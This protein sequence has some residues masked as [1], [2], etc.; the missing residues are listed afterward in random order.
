MPHDAREGEQ[1]PYLDEACNL[2]TLGCDPPNREAWV[3][4]QSPNMTPAKTSPAMASIYSQSPIPSVKSP[5]TSAYDSLSR[6]ILDFV[7]VSSVSVPGS[8]SSILETVLPTPASLGYSETAIMPSSTD[9]MANTLKPAHDNHEGHKRTLSRPMPIMMVKEPIGELSFARGTII[10]KDSKGIEFP[11]QC[12]QVKITA[13]PSSEKTGMTGYR[14]EGTALMNV[15]SPAGG[16]FQYELPTS[17]ST[18]GSQEIS[19]NMLVMQSPPDHSTDF[20]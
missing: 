13:D 4:S 19:R 17:A 6:E 8:C 7:P 5:W 15:N 16:L 11:L 10:V 12:N 1:P 9:F 2:E 3:P 18:Q 14:V 20:T